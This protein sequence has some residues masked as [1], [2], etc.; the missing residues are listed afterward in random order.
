MP[1][2]T[3][4]NEPLVKFDLKYQII[5]ISVSCRILIIY[6]DNHNLVV[7]YY[8]TYTELL[9]TVRC[10]RTSRFH[11]RALIGILKSNFQ[12]ISCLLQNENRLFSLSLPSQLQNRD[13]RGDI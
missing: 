13:V 7:S 5:N 3:M 10:F 4:I 1:H 12:Y 6:G 2:T 11:N 9:V 8:F